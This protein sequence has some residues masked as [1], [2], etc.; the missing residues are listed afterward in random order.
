M[1]CCGGRV[2]RVK[3]EVVVAPV[4]SI[5]SMPMSTFITLTMDCKEL[6]SVDSFINKRSYPRGCPPKAVGVIQTKSGSYVWVSMVSVEVPEDEAAQNGIPRLAGANF[7]WEWSPGK[8]M[9]CWSILRNAE[10][11]DGI[12]RPLAHTHPTFDASEYLLDPRYVECEEVSWSE[13][14]PGDRWFIS[15][16]KPLSTCLVAPSY[17]EDA[18]RK[19]H[20]KLID[21][22][23]SRGPP[24]AVNSLFWSNNC[25][26]D[27][28]TLSRLD[29]WCYTSTDRIS[30]VDME[31][32]TPY[33]I[34]PATP[35][36]RQGV[37]VTKLP[38]E[39]MEE[40]LE[41][42][43]RQCVGLTSGEE[44]WPVHVATTLRCVCKDFRNRLD[45]TLDILREEILECAKETLRG[46]CSKPWCFPLR[47]GRVTT[48]FRDRI[49]WRH[50][51]TEYRKLV[52][53]RHSTFS[54][55]THHA[56]LPGSNNTIAEATMKQKIATRQ[57]LIDNIR[58]MN[59]SATPSLRSNH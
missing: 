53:D 4:Q 32:C 27:D 51:N 19:R 15:H 5:C 29:L 16:V 13:L 54:M 36:R 49:T 52:T 26:H 23:R 25:W 1:F 17:E 21:T 59:P 44:R 50:I 40:V 20:N 10:Q 58:S 7:I 9:H 33:S 48:V 45:N 37:D 28:E 43:A 46:Q 55:N 56:C 8:A 42:V 11:N 57:R 30:K 38:N 31:R 47:V 2:Y 24:I 14:S 6:W 39:I 22:R 35:K 3:K 18:Y 34:L 41:I 12:F